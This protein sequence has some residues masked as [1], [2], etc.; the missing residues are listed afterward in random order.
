MKRFL[1]IIIAIIFIGL[2]GFIY[3]RY[4]WVFG[5]G[6]KT[7]QLNYV[8]KKG[9]I[10][11]TYEGKLIQAGFRSGSPGTVQSY[12]FEFS[13]EDDDIAQK[14]MLNSGKEV[15]LRYKEYNASV[16][17]RGYS[18]YIVDSIIAIRDPH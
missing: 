4:F 17:W 6:V 13:V 10:F 12:E 8:V 14:L 15:D 18:R 5:D 11:K 1:F 16:P 3:W 9:Y 2:A 7:G